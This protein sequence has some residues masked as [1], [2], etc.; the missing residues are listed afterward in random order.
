MA[1]LPTG[2]VNIGSPVTVVN[3]S[4]LTWYCDQVS[5]RINGTCDGYTAVKQAVEIILNTERFKWQIYS[6]SSGTEYRGLLGQDEGYVAVELQRRIR[7]ALLMDNRVTGISNYA[8]TLSDGSLIA[9]FTVNTVYGSI[10]EQAEV[11]I[12]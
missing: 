10:P 3:E 1:T 2:A 11:V 6:P 5:G 12:S 8:Y 7:E 4:S 9:S